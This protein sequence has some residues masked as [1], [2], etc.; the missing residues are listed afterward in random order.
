MIELV[1]IDERLLH[2][3]V[4]VGWGQRL[5]LG[6]YVVADDDLAAS[7]WEQELY[8]GGLPGSARAFFLTVDEAAV[9][10]GQLDEH[11]GRGA[12]LTRTTGAMRRLAE[13]GA[14]EGRAVNLGCLGGAPGRSRALDYV[15]LSPDEVEDLRAI[16]A[17]A[18]PVTARDLPSSPRVPLE[19]VLRDLDG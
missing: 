14:L 15:H 18:G 16:A 3:Q 19:K 13:A 5:D 9:R 10:F 12:L 11:A 6:Y 2:G 17:R 1:R 4:I 7:E 8:A